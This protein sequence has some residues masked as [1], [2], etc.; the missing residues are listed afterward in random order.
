MKKVAFYTI[1]SLVAVGSFAQKAT[2]QTPVPSP[3]LTEGRLNI[4]INKVRP[5]GKGWYIYG[6]VSYGLPFLQ[7]NRFSPYK[8]VGKLDWFQSPDSLSVKPIYGTLGGGW[9]ANFGWGHMFNKYIGI[10]V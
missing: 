5:E 6:S 1:L 9:A 8:E 4:R 3:S 10:D 7:T 2:K